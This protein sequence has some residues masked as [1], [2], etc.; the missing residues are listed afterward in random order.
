MEIL[1]DILALVVT[2]SIL[3]TI[4]EW[5]HFIVARFFNVK[6]IRFSVGF[7][8]PLY[9]FY[10]KTPNYAPAA[11]DQEIQTRSNEQDKGTEFAI[12]A[13]PLGGYVKMLDE[14]E[15]FVPDD[16]LHLA[17]NRKPVLQRIAIVLAGPLANF[18]LAIFAYWVLF[19]AGVTGLVPVI[20]EVKQDSKADIAG[21]QQG[22]EIVEID[23]EPV[24]TWAQV[25]LGLFKRIGETGQI[26][27]GIR[28]S[29]ES[30]TQTYQIHVD[31]WLRDVE[32]PS[33]ASDLGISLD[34]PPSPAIISE[35]IAGKPAEK[36]GMAVGD[37]IISV[38]GEPIGDWNQWVKK[39]QI[40]PEKSLGVQ[41]QRESREMELLLVPE[42]QERDGKEIG[43]I[44]AG[45]VRVEFPTDRLR[46][47][48]YPLYSA[49]IPALEKTWTVTVFTMD[50]LGKLVSGAISHKNL[51]GPITIA[52]IASDTASSG[53]ESFIQFLALL[54]ISLGILNLLPI[55]VLD[56]GHFLYY[57]VELISGRPIPEKVQLWGLQI[58]LFLIIGVMVLAFYN[59]LTSL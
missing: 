20:G 9:S 4:H 53:L 13:I 15:A 54:S 31:E 58:G 34:L 35:L 52:R 8:K 25:N 37:R 38:D 10:G 45:G 57:L 42:R 23:G 27:L 6:V 11:E 44:G 41:I 33:P 56:G 50:S 47:T 36:A 16:Q 22:Q 49:W 17:F 26:N 3:V 40:N 18:L 43:Y 28:R 2:I 1:K 5:G 7:G 48:R 21:L 24:E 51:S 32:K 55:P 46:T 19:S 39:I 14:R 29:G 12:A 30:A 59:D